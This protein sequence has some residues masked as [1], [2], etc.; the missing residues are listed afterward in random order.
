MEQRD[1][2]I[3]MGA[4]G[5]TT[6]LFKHNKFVIPGTK[7]YD[8]LEK[9]PHIAKLLIKKLKPEDGDIVM[10]G[11]AVTSIRIAEFA[12]LL[13]MLNHESPM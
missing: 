13:T 5:A 6:L 12:A 3:K 1:A 10:I 11:S 8:S 9:E 2:A 4:T 7:N